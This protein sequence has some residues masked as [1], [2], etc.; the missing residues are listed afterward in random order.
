LL[1]KYV[2]I[3]R[4]GSIDIETGLHRPNFHCSYRPRYNA[5]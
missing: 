4:D 1:K 5:Q 3:S 2:Q